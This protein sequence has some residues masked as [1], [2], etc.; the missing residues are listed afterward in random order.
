MSG[1]GTEGGTPT[2]PGT[3]TPT[4]PTPGGTTPA[5]PAPPRPTR[6]AK[7]TFANTR[8]STD[9]GTPRWD[10]WVGGKP[11]PGLTDLEDPNP[12]YI[13]PNQFRS[14]SVASQSKSHHYRT[15]GLDTKF[16]RSS[17]LLTFQKN[18]WKHL[19]NHGLD[20]I[21]YLK[22]PM[23]PQQVVSV[24]DS[25]ALFTLKTA[26]AEANTFRTTLDNHG[27]SMD[28]DATDFLLNSLDEDLQTQL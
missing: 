6:P 17:D 10:I 28:R 22:D 26:V 16:T 23:N 5:T 12:A 27:H 13:A 24:V 15:S 8:L 2:P 1:T 4:P 18:L 7:P 25:H 9:G 14:T 11:N 21:T 3:P 20:S 19:V